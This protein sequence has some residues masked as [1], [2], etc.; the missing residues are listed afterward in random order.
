MKLEKSATSLLYTYDYRKATQIQQL[1]I[2]QHFV[3]FKRTIAHS[4]IEITKI[5]Q[6]TN[7]YIFLAHHHT[8][9][10]AVLYSCMLVGQ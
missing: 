2:I 5:L 7:P 1:V 8:S 10:Q 9:T 6:N 3:Q 4:F